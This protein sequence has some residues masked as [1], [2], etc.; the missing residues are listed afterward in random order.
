MIGLQK[1]CAKREREVKDRILT[2]AH[3][4]T[5]WHYLK[6]GYDSGEQ[7]RG[8]AR[9]KATV[10]KFEADSISLQIADSRRRAQAL[11]SGLSAEQLMRR[12]DPGKWSIA[13]CIAHLNLTAA[14]VQ[15]LMAKGIQ[16]CKGK[17]I[18]GEGPFSIGPK[19]RLLV[20]IAEPP[21]NSEFAHP[22]TCVRPQQS[23]ILHRYCPFL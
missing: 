20:W 10:M 7:S 22:R 9:L 1:A 18:S 3:I 21:P 17:G 2:R 8:F 6:W 15:P 13:E 23:T 11:V 12:P 19:G 14:A 5:A 4:G 16:S